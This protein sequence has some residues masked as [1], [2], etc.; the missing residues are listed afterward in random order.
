MV[1]H[2]SGTLENECKKA[3]ATL[4]GLSLSA[5]IWSVALQ[6][7]S[8]V[9]RPRAPVGASPGKQAIPFSER[10]ISPL[11][12]YVICTNPRSGSWLLSEGLASTSQAGNPREWFNSLE[13][14]EARAWWRTHNS[15]DVTDATYCRHVLSE[16]TTSNGIFGIKLHYYQFVELSKRLTVE[17][18]RGLPTAEV[19]STAF[20]KVR[21]LWLTRRDKARQAISYYLAYKTDE[22]WLIDG[23]KPKYEDKIDALAF[24]PYAIADLEQTLVQNDRNWQ[25]WFESNKITPLTIYYEDLAIDYHGSILNV[26]KW[27]GVPKVQGV[28]I[29]RPRLNRQSNARNEEWL[30]HYRAFK[31]ERGNRLQGSPSLAISSPLFDRAQQPFQSIPDAWKQ[32]IV[33]NKRLGTTDDTIIDVLMSNGYSRESATAEVGKV[34]SDPYLLAAAESERCRNK[35]VSLLNVL[36][37]S[38]GLDSQAKVVERRTN[39]SRDEFRDRYYA[40]N[41]PVIIEGLMTAWRAVE[42]WTADYLKGMAGDQ[43][44]EIM[45][46]RD[47]DPKYEIN[48]PNHRTMV[49]FADYI[50]RVYGGLVSN[51]QYLVANNRFFQQPETRSL[52]DDF[53]S[54]REY[55]DPATVGE[56]CFL[57]FGPAGTIT[58]LHHDSCNILIAQVVG[59][60]RFRLISA[61]QWPYVY[62]NIGVY[63]D[64]DC[65]NPDLDRHPLFRHAN[66]IDVV[67]EPGQVLFL[68]VGWWHHVRA[69]DVSISISFTNFVFPNHF[70]WEP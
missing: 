12:T 26:L 4:G 6:R 11:A 51:D 10:G 24:D 9:Q 41:R 3:I 47:A 33:R 13:E 53:A 5:G 50:D 29:P 45:A 69:L 59:R 19:M 55:L 65:E 46:G 30:A 31:T 61:L 68:P 62:N 17:S 2:T 37:K 7:A 35:A 8:G 63:S 58:P 16:G 67:L 14:Q 56:R 23:I 40:A 20:P 18:H 32:W 70:N 39:L 57:W 38:A 66:P 52:M 36:Q 64:V 21:Y 25:S 1:D 15:S 44:I 43:L 48:A 54:F 28:A 22:W 60:K 34:A 27:L 49:R 42:T